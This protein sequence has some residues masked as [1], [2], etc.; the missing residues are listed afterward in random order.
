MPPTKTEPSST[1]A[2]ITGSGLASAFARLAAAPRAQTT[3]QRIR[4]TRFA[5]DRRDCS[6]EIRLLPTDHDDGEV[7]GEIAARE[8]ARGLGERCC[9]FADRQLLLLPDGRGKALVAG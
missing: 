8:L 3:R 4:P 6:C 5:T 7:V 9:Q 2:A 1:P